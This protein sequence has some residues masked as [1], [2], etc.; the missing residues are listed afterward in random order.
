MEGNNKVLDLSVLSDVDFAKVKS[1]W[2]KHMSSTVSTYF[3]QVDKTSLKYLNRAFNY[4]DGSSFVKGGL[5]VTGVYFAGKLI[6]K[7]C[8]KEE[9]NKDE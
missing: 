2:D 4:V 7:Y 5:F 6:H 3:G 8:T 1:G 9:N